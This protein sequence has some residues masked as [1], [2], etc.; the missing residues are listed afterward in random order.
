LN[1]LHA[2]SQC[3]SFS[4]RYEPSSA[5]KGRIASRY[6]ELGYRLA[7]RRLELN[8]DWLAEVERVLRRR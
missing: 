4:K 2:V 7:H 8:R 6:L 5:R 1:H 3:H